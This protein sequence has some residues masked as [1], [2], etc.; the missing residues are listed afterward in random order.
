MSKVAL[1]HNDIIN[2]K[3]GGTKQKWGNVSIL[4]CIRLTMAWF[5][6]LCHYAWGLQHIEVEINTCFFKRR[7]LGN[8]Y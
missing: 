1:L 2:Q 4:L 6:M 8:S 5:L 3:Q 7:G